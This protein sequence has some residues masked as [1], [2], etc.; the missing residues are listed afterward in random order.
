MSKP[1][2]G[3]TTSAR[4]GWR[5]FPLVALNI[6]LAGGKAVRWGAGRP[7][8]VS[9]IDGIIIGG[10]DDISPDFYGGDLVTSARLDPAR[11]ALELGTGPELAAEDV[12]LAIRHLGAVVGSVGVEDVLGAVF[13]QFCIG[14]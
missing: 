9:K 3:V 7:S 13:S 8:D 10:G 11:D 14:K 1:L 5:I 4:S 12:R 2:I 6:W